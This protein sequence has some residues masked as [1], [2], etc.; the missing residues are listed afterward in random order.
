[1]GLTQRQAEEVIRPIAQAYDRYASTRANKARINTATAVA[2][3]ELDTRVVHAKV[4]I[5]DLAG[6]VNWD[7]GYR[8]PK[9]WLLE[10]IITNWDAYEA[11]SIASP[12]Y[13]AL[14]DAGYV[15]E[16]DINEA[17]FFKQPEYMRFIVAL[18]T[19]RK[20]WGDIAAPFSALIVGTTIATSEKEVLKAC[21]DFLETLK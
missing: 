9:Q 19:T 6:G 12:L 5:E 17:S 2:K 4:I 1:M 18:R 20:S 7:Y 3:W 8:N 11:G 10:S 16:P 15:K 21:D 14:S 13:E